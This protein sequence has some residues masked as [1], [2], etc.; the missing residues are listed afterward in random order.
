MKV[1]IQNYKKSINESEFSLAEIAMIWDFYVTHAIAKSAN[2]RRPLKDYGIQN[3]PWDKMLEVANIQNDNCKILL[4]DSINKTL[5]KLDLETV[6]KKK[7]GENKDKKENKAIEIDIPKIVCIT[8][9]TISDEEKPKPKFGEAE[10]V[11]T[12]IRNSFA[13]GLTY[14]FD[15]GNILFEDKNQRG[16]I[17]SRIILKQ[18]TLLDWIKLIDV[19][20]KFYKFNNLCNLCNIEDK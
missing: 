9:Y 13:H 15:N 12:H 8:P 2:Q 19:K 5:T 3:L 6:E 18:Q 17:T 14:F 7:D 20:E 4:A 1:E 16:I 10:S 11:L